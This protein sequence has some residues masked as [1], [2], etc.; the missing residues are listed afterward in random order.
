MR[1]RAL[2]ALGGSA[3]SLSVT[4]CLDNSGDTSTTTRAPP[5][6]ECDEA[7]RP[8]PEPP[9][10]DDLVQP[11]EYPGPPPAQLN[12]ESAIEYVEQFERSYRTNMELSQTYRLHL[13][14]VSV[15]ETQ[16]FDTPGEAAV[17]RLRT[18]FSGTAQTEE[19]EGELHYDI[20][21]AYVSYYVDSAVVVR[22]EKRSQSE[23]DT[24]ELDPDPF[25]SGEPVACFE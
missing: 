22:A 23:V 5:D 4:G 15:A 3:L 20:W 12:D 25:E 16:V 24:D 14:S 7:S 11:A 18:H 17:V 21:D 9:D 19:A 2:L 6:V 10:G 13:I 8:Q 1:R